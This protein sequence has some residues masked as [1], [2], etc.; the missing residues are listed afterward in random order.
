MV[1]VVTPCRDKVA[2]MALAEEQ[3][4]VEALILQASARQQ[5][6][7]RVV[8]LVSSPTDDGRMGASDLPPDLQSAA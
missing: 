7:D 2:R 8:S 1:V 4:P 3:G 6:N 5:T